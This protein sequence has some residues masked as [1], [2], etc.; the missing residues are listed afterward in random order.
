MIMQKLLKK[1]LLILQKVVEQTVNVTKFISG[2][3]NQYF[4]IL[5]SGIL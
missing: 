3:E 4:S 1:K 2:K 5:N